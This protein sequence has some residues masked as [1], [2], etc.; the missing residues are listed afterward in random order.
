MKIV[1]PLRQIG[2]VADNFFGAQAA[3][4]VSGQSS[5][6]NPVSPLKLA[7]SSACEEGG[8]RC[9]AVKCIDMTQNSDCEG[10]FPARY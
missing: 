10:S 9:V 7:C 3:R 4:Q 5:G 6:L 2:P 1:L 8:M